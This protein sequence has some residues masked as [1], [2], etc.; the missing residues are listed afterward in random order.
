LKKKR[1]LLNYFGSL[2]AVA[3]ATVEEFL[4]VPGITRNQA[5]SIA[6]FFS[7]NPNSIG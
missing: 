3:G 6:G 4:R 7:G 1:A 2:D 5:E